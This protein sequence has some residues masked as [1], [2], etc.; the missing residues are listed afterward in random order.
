MLGSRP[1]PADVRGLLGAPAGRVL[2]ARR[3]S[4]KGDVAPLSVSRM[5]LLELWWCSKLPGLDLGTGELET[6][7]GLDRSPP[8][9]GAAL[10]TG[11]DPI[12]F[13]FAL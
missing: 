1:A 12:L 5:V 11:R 7:N 8:L 3:R 4:L 9:I 6:G 10:S 2:L 13:E